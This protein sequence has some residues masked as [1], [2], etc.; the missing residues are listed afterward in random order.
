MELHIVKN[1]EEL[2]QAVA[3]WMVEY[4]NKVLQKQDKFT[5][6]L[7]GGST[8]KML[9]EL[10]A[11]DKYSN[12][13]DWPK[14]HIF[15]G[16]ERFVPFKDARNNAGMA[17]DTLLNY[18][19]VLPENIHIMQTEHTTPEASANDYTQILL[20]YF[21]PPSGTT[22]LV[23]NKKTFDLVLLGMGDDGHTLSLFPGKTEIIHEIN[24]WCLAFWADE[25]N[26]YRITL[27]HN[28]ANHA[29]CI[30]FLVSGAAK[31]KAL[32]EVLE[33]AYNPDVYPSQIIN[34][35]HNNLQW[36]VDEAAAEF[37]KLKP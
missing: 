27:T 4:I 18:V 13:I 23:E 10:L 11:S 35:N 31:A 24:K 26:M 6:A 1:K 37:L 12:K 16:D 21:Q 19:N 2:S 34:S 5:L 25:Q 20:Q 33:G 15:F 17:Y 29:G 8:P 22:D 7:S 30:V 3:D 32:K 14:V 28:V 36:F 9:H